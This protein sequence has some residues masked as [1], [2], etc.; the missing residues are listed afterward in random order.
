[1]SQFI[2]FSFPL[3]PRM[4][5]FLQ[6]RDGLTCLTESNADQQAY[7]WLQ[8]C[9]DL[10]VSLL[11]EQGRR[12]ALADVIA[13]LDSMQEHLTALADEHPQY[14]HQI[15]RSCTTLQ[16]HE[17]N[18]RGGI[19]QAKEIL[20]SDALISAWINSLKKHD[21]LGH[22]KHMPHALHALWNNKQRRQGV[23]D[24]LRNLHEAVTSL[25]G[26]LHDYVAWESH[27]ATGGGY[28][29]KLNSEQ[30]CGLLIVGLLSEQVDAGLVPDISGNH[31]AIRL[32]FQRWQPAQAAVQVD[33]DIPFQC[34][35]VPVA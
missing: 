1:M 24:A 26:M 2:R 32:R 31:L 33:E 19:D 21:W 25:H 16:Q 6:L 7:I 17:K 28:R 3:S 8:A 10:R 20:T 12:A 34:M 9:A 29:F 11:G 22:Q 14:S 4:Q 30:P 13:L 18:L 15:M 5:S 27:T 35:L 23:H